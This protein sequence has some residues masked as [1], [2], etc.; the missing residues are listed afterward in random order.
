M[1]SIDLEAS[2]AEAEIC[3]VT[4]VD[5][6]GTTSEIWK[7]FGLQADSNGKALSNGSAICKIC[8]CKI[9]AKSGN[10]SNL[11]SHLRRKHPSI[12]AQTFFPSQGK[13]KAKPPKATG[14]MSITSA[15][16][17]GVPYDRKSKKWN[18]L[19]K[20]VTYCI[21]KDGL[22]LRVV[23][24]DGFKRMLKTFDPRYELPSRSYISRTSV[25]AMYAATV[26]KVKDELHGVSYFAATTDMWSS[27]AG[28]RRYTIRTMIGTFKLYHLEHTTFQRIT[29]LLY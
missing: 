14:Q 19:T 26:K 7:Y 17:Q 15:F 22:P 20:M 12:Y 3:Q 5:K 2:V 23:E 6:P 13:A 1:A 18:E 24:K 4:I 16:A 8:Q 27:T 25:P 10:T 11:I 29:L 28:L 9:A 21:V